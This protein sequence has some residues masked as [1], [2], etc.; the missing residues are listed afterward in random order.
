MSGHPCISSHQ[1]ALAIQWLLE[2]KNNQPQ[3]SL[4]HTHR[5]CDI[6]CTHIQEFLGKVDAY[7]LS[8][9]QPVVF[10]ADGVLLLI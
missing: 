6:T 2:L 9:L 10:D 7:M 5:T 3:V 4:T 1:C 8:P